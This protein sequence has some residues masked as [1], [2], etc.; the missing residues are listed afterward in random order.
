MRAYLGTYLIL[1]SL[2]VNPAVGREAPVTIV[3]NDNR[4]PAGSLRDNVLTLHLE[5]RDG[6]LYPEEDGGPGLPALAFAE[7]GRDAQNPGPLIRVHAGTMVRVSVR[8]PFRDSV[9]TVHGLGD[10]AGAPISALRIPGGQTREARFRASTEGTYFYWAS[11]GDRNIEGRRWFES[12]LTGALVVDPPGARQDDRIFV[13]G[14]RFREG[15]TTLAVPRRPQDMMVINGKSWP[16]TER[17]TYDQGDTVRW[18]W[19]NPSSSAHPM[20]LHGFY[21]SVASKGTWER[22]HTYDGEARPLIV[23]NLMLPGETMR[24]SWIPERPGNW[25]FHCHFAFHVSHHLVLGRSESGAIAHSATTVPHRMAGLV[26]GIHVKPKGVSPAVPLTSRKSR[27]IRLLAQMSPN[28]FG[29]LTGFGYVT[30]EGATEPKRDS[31]QIPGPMLVLKRGEPV[32]ITVVNH[33]KETTAV[34][35]HGIELESFPDG[36]PGW[37]GT[38]GRTMPPIAPA[39]SFIAEFVPPRAGTFI[40]HTHANEQ[41]QMGAGLYGTLLVVPADKPY[42]PEYD[43]VIIVGGAGPAD[44]LPNFESPGLVN[45]STAP[46]PLELKMG[47]TYRLRMININPDWRVIFSITS[48]SAMATWRPMAMDG[49]DL[50]LSQRKVAPAWLL[51]GPGQT[52]DVEFTPAVRGELRLEIKTMIAGWIIPMTLRVR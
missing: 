5:V 48:D 31:V 20:H 4:T 35:W 22:E 25:L 34:H 9:L 27:S 47:K 32:R 15:D 49:A 30:Q 16:H 19:I 33:L 39:D 11:T 43:K 2:P 8:N 28:R 1:L 46:P 3:A 21:Y 10:H 6:I 41:L 50:P 45:G 29:K 17:F 13:I 23:T 14:V 7:V 38:P 40:Y 52:A 36:V 51:T 42:D 12:Q 26:L 44:S 37:S 18:R 24:V